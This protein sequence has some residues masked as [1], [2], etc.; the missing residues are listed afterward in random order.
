[1]SASTDVEPWHRYVVG[2][3]KAKKKNRGAT[4][5]RGGTC[6]AARWRELGDGAAGSAEGEEETLNV[7]PVAELPSDV[8]SGAVVSDGAQ[9]DDEHTVAPT[10]ARGALAGPAAAQRKQEH[11]IGSGSGK[12]DASDME[13]QEPS[14][15]IAA[16]SA[17]G[18][19][20]GDKSN[21]LPAE[22]RPT[23]VDQSMSIPTPAYGDAVEDEAAF[24]KMLDDLCA[25]AAQQ[26]AETGIESD[27]DDNVAPPPLTMITRG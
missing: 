9:A 13:G 14:A 16:R 22:R 21:F 24:A 3:P 17:E 19:V 8:V 4:F 11:V 20:V 18:P 10:A 7:T 12:Q 26:L 5:R 27:D 2:A 15:A 23:P 25:R 6:H 1:M